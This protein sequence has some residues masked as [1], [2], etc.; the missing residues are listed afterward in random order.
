MRRT[1]TAAVLA[2]AL[3]APAA[4]QAPGGGAPINL[5]DYWILA[6]IRNPGTGEAAAFRVD[7]SDQ[8]PI[9]CKGGPDPAAALRL[10]L[11]Q[12]CGSVFGKPSDE[13]PAFVRAEIGP[14]YPGIVEY[15]ASGVG[16]FAIANVAMGIPLDTFMGQAA[17][18][19]ELRRPEGFSAPIATTRPDCSHV[20]VSD[21]RLTMWL[22]TPEELAAREAAA[23]AGPGEPG[24][25]LPKRKGRRR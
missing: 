16:G 18:F 5:R 15:M 23:E 12:L 3:A 2:A 4:A 9:L 11:A 19:A 20:A 6:E 1:V 7:C 25:P 24:A 10:H 13:W 17:A 8:S 21:I 22:V 14:F